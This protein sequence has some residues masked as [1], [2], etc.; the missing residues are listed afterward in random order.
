MTYR[1]DWTI[2]LIECQTGIVPFE[3][4]MGDDLPCLLLE[5]VDDLFV[6]NLKHDAGWQN[7]APMRHHFLVGAVIAT[8][9]PKIVGIKLAMP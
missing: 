2:R 8:Q 1:P 3:T 7:I 4:A 5:I 6:S 9:F